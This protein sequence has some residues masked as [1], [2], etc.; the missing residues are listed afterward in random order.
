MVLLNQVK[1]P[2]IY[3]LLLYK[4]IMAKH[5]QDWLDKIVFL[6]LTIVFLITQFLGIYVSLVLFSAGLSKG[7]IDPD[8]NSINNSILLI[9]QILIFTGILLVVLKFSKKNRALWIIEFFAV[10]M[11]SLIFFTVFFPTNDLL[12]IL[13]VVIILGLRYLNRENILIKNVV[14]IIAIVGAGGLIG[15]TMGTFP[16]LVF[17]ILLSIYDYIAVF[18]TKH[19]ITLSKAVVKNNFAF[20]ISFPSKKH[21]FELGNGDLIIPL[22]VVSSIISNGLF[23]NNLLVAFL[24]SIASLIGL[25]IS[26]YIVSVKK[27]PL[28]ALPPQTFLMVLVI[29]ISLIFKF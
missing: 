7:V 16:V 14:S 22:I 2:N 25:F 15:I 4:L 9:F 18:K 5:S 29:I 21:N 24:C 26:I 19:M 1:E 27:I 8:I 13:F 28:P 6:K 3:N 23:L 10:L 17:I 20:T 11:S 12:V